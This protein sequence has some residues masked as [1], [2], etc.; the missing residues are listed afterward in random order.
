MQLQCSHCCWAGSQWPF[1]AVLLPTVIKDSVGVTWH[2]PAHLGLVQGDF[3]QIQSDGYF[4]DKNSHLNFCFF[5]VPLHKRGIMHDDGQRRE[6]AG[7]HA[8]TALVSRREPGPP[9]SQCLCRTSPEMAP[10]RKHLPHCPQLADP[11]TMSPEKKG[12]PQR[13]SVGI[14]GKAAPKAFNTN[15]LCHSFCTRF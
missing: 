11:C 14:L 8:L 6:A 3:I 5:P 10:A 7:P 12:T 4:R 15:L 1:Q 13:M 2:R 9:E